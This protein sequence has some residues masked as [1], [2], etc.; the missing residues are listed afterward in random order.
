MPFTR[1]D[2]QKV[3]LCV[4]PADEPAGLESD[5]ADWLARP[6]EGAVCIRY[7]AQENV[8]FDR[9]E[10]SFGYQWLDHVERF[11]IPEGTGPTKW[12]QLALQI[13]PDGAVSVLVDRVSILESRVR[14]PI[15]PDS[16]WRIRLSGA[17]VDTHLY[18]RRLTVWPG[19]RYPG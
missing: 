15:P 16:R 4:E 12:V 18:I 14:V 8:K 5:Q 1:T 13:R 2:R 11:R 7:P 3:G 6:S 10:G 17:A 19:Q 9:F